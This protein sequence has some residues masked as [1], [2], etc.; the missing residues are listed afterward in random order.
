MPAVRSPLLVFLRRPKPTDTCCCLTL[1]EG[2]AQA[3]IH[4]ETFDVR[5]HGWGR[6][7]CYITSSCK[8]ESTSQDNPSRTF[9]AEDQYRRKTSADFAHAD[10][11]RARQRAPLT[12]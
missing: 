6:E 9:A 10:A 8:L 4:G 11:Q 12:K 7:Y 5:L 1:R 3:S 2:F